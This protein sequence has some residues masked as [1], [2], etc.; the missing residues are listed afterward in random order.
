MGQKESVC[1]NSRTFA[2]RQF[3][4]PNMAVSKIGPYFRNRCPQR[5]NK[6]NFDALGQ[7]ERVCVWNKFQNTC[8]WQ[9]SCPNMTILKFGPRL[10]NHSPQNKLK[11]SISTPGMAESLCATSRTS[12]VLQISCLFYTKTGMQILNLPANSLFQFFFFKFK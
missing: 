1:V 11:R 6:L 4:C 10:G 9:V 3:S 8:Q 7:R 5:K 2:T 12:S